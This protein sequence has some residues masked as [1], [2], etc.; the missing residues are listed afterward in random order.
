MNIIKRYIVSNLRLKLLSLMLAIML[1]FAVSHMGETSMSISVP[2]SYINLNRSYIIKEITNEEVLVK[3]NGP[4]S[5]LKTLKSKDIVLIVDLS[6]AHEGKN[7]YNIGDKN[8]K[9]K[10]PNTIKVETINPDYVI[11]DIDR[12]IEKRLKIIV[13]VDERLS[14]DYMVKSWKPRYV[15]VYGAR[16]SLAN[17]KTIETMPVTGSFKSEEVVVNT[18]F[19][20]KGLILKAI[21]PETATVILGRRQKGP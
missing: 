11:F 6:Y 13:N 7:V 21:R 12:L 17:I 15:T 19:N 1:W 10:V 4:V 9:T 5:K 18:P 20:T 2:V 16:A 3:V 8:V 14:E